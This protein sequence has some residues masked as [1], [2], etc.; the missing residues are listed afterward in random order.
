MRPI[1]PNG[2]RDNDRQRRPD[3]ELHAQRLG[4]VDNPEYFKQNRD[5]D[6]AAANAEQSGEEAGD[7]AG[8]DSG[9]R[10]PDQFA[11]GCSEVYSAA[12]LIDGAGVPTPVGRSNSSAGSRS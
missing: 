1:G 9:D 12:S 10:Q 6:G 3:A 2:R 11:K 4:H 8:G 5:D 7:D